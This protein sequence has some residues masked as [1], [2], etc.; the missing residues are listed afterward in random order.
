MPPLSTIQPASATAQL[1]F[2]NNYSL[3]STFD[4][5]VLEIS[6]NGGGTFSDIVTAGGS[7]VSGGYNATIST[8]Y[9]SP[10]AGRMAWS[11]SSGGFL[12]TTVNLPASANGQTTVLRWRMAS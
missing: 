7:F 9:S 8:A 3:E 4:G 11:G 1:S 5:G 6:I 12:T 10:I 2:R